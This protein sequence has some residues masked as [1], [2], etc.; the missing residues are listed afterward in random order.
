[1]AQDKRLYKRRG[2]GLALFLDPSLP[3]SSLS[4]PLATLS[5]PNSRQS[6][7]SDAR[8]LAIVVSQPFHDYV[9][10]KK[11]F[12]VNTPSCSDTCSTSWSSPPSSRHSAAVHP[13][14]MRRQPSLFPSDSFART[15]DDAIA[16]SLSPPVSRLL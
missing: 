8:C 6:F 16:T 12:G 11:L 1:M 15:S 10:L 2:E 9:T 7:S 4:C 14:V 5:R 13:A 3:P